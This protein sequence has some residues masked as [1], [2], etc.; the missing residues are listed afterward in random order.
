[1]DK[2]EWHLRYVFFFPIL[3]EFSPASMCE[4]WILSTDHDAHRISKGASKPAATMDGT[5]TYGLSGCSSRSSIA[6]SKVSKLVSSKTSD[7]S[8][9]LQRRPKPSS[10]ISGCR[11]SNHNLEHSQSTAYP[12]RCVYGL[13]RQII[14]AAINSQCQWSKQQPVGLRYFL[15]QFCLLSSASRQGLKWLV[16]RFMIYLLCWC[17]CTMIFVYICVVLLFY[18]CDVFC[19]HLGVL[20]TPRFTCVTHFNST[21]YGSSISVLLIATSTAT[22]LVA[23]IMVLDFAIKL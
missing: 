5:I 10:P 6:S 18:V 2:E 19:L 17:T 13:N 12:V 7:C 22:T 16:S 23:L 9:M 11:Q 14:P 1:M 20:Y 8:T 21:G 15:K 3:W 4:C